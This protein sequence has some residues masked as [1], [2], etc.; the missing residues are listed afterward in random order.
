MPTYFKDGRL[1][2]GKTEVVGLKAAYEIRS[3]PWRHSGI[4]VLAFTNAAA[5]VIRERIGQFAG[6]LTFPHFVGTVDSW[7]HGYVLNPF[8]HPITKFPGREGDRSVRTVEPASAASFLHGFAKKYHYA[9]RGPVL[10]HQFHRDLEHDRLVFESS[11]RNLDRL[12]QSQDLQEWQTRD[13]MDAKHRFW[14]KGFATYQDAE[15]ICHL[16][17]QNRGALCALLAERF[18]VFIIDE[19]QDLSWAQMEVLRV[20]RARGSSLH[21]VGDLDQAIYGFREVCPDKVRGF[22]QKTGLATLPLSMNYRGVQPIVN[23]C[24]RLVPSRQTVKGQPVQGA[25]CACVYFAYG[26]NEPAAVVAAFEGYLARR[27]IVTERAAI[28]AR[29]HALVAKLRPSS[30][31]LPDKGGICL[32]M[33]VHLWQQGGAQQLDEVLLCMG[34]FVTAKLWPQQHTDAR[35]HHC[36][37][38]QSSPL[39]W[40][41]FLARL[42]DTC[43]NTREMADLTLPWATWA[44]RVRA[45]LPQLL[46]QCLGDDAPESPKSGWFRALPGEG[47]KPVIDSLATARTA[48]QSGVLITTIHQAKGETYDAVLLVSSPTRIGDGGHWSH[49]SDSSGGDGEHAR[50]A[51]VASS[52]PRLLLAWAVPAGDAEAVRRLEAL[53]FAPADAFSPSDLQQG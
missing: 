48:P 32:A 33:A 7:L 17:L 19:C 16:L 9:Q 40:R 45:N 23:V 28:L 53:G 10:A 14:A 21:L 41:L 42:L 31:R 2:S 24:S 46:A 44:E 3:W 34:R 13:L 47:D 22:I 36:P 43:L 39:R 12:R 5:T 38:I 8:G 26:R 6:T 49:W 20:L 35:H 1:G 52:R 4:A 15:V 51:Y 27:G 11:D 30:G 50:F 18:P 29:G 25:E 37:E